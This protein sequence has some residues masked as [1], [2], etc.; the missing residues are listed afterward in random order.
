MIIDK[1]FCPICDETNLIIENTKIKNSIATIYSCNNS[2][3]SLSFLDTWNNKEYVNQLYVNDE[4]IFE[5]NVDIEHES[6]MKF[7]EYI[8]YFDFVSPYLSKDKKL[9]DI[10]CGDGKFLKLVSNK[11]SCAE[12]IELAPSQ[13]TK[14]RELGFNCY[15]KMIGDLEPKHQYDVVTMFALLEHVPFVKDFLANLKNYIHTNSDIFIVVPNLF[16]PLVSSYKINEFKDFYYR[17]VHLYYFNPISIRKLFEE[18]G[19]SVEIKTMQQASITNHFHWIN[20]KG[21]QKNSNYMSS[22][23]LPDSARDSKEITQIMNK[24]DD[25]YRELINNNELGDLIYVHAK[26]KS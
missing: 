20:K 8:T 10:G 24:V 3:C 15:D 21:P 7:N 1:I 16:D 17:D 13:V 18:S 2:S 14:V 9:L 5:H 4:Y 23:T 6:E 22:V 11:V 19:Y 12:G 26:Q 25:Y